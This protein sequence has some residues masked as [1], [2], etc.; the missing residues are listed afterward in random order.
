KISCPDSPWG[1]QSCLPADK[2]CL[3]HGIHYRVVPWSIIARSGASPETNFGTK[4]ATLLRDTRLRVTFGSESCEVA[5]RVAA[6]TPPAQAKRLA[7]AA[8]SKE[9][10]SAGS[11]ASSDS[12]SKES[13]PRITGT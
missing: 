11:A 2:E 8:T 4:P 3:P 9:T 12:R 7:G 10:V 13:S 5:Q 6:A 1:R